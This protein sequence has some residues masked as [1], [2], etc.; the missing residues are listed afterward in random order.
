M[1]KLQDYE[2]EQEYKEYLDE[3]FPNYVIM[4]MEYT[5]SDILQNCD[6]I[7]YR[8]GVSDYAGTVECD[9]CGNCLVD[10]TCTGDN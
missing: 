2:I 8:V 6:P 9:D 5:A 7:A 1:P 10:C 3:C 4:G